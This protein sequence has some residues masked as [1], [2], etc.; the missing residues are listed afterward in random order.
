MRGLGERGQARGPA[1][2]GEP[3][4]CGAGSP[5]WSWQGCPGTCILGRQDR[6][7]Q[8]GE[9]Q[10]GQAGAGIPRGVSLPLPQQGKAWTPPSPRSPSKG[11]VEG[12]MVL[13]TSAHFRP[14]CITGVD[15]LALPTGQPIDANAWKSFYHQLVPG[16][17]AAKKMPQIWAPLGRAAD[18][19]GAGQPPAS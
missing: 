15:P 8:E 18:P 5:S 13:K 17:S 7:E 16:A 4:A 1:L 3:N 9:G 10:A 14:I 12:T 19:G 6:Q 11:P 2:C